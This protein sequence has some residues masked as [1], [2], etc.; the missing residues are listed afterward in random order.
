MDYAEILESIRKILSQPIVLVI[1]TALTAIG[2]LIAA[3]AAVKANKPN[4]REKTD[5][6]KCELLN[7]LHSSTGLEVW[8]RS[9]SLGTLNPNTISEFLDI[10]RSKQIIPS[11]IRIG[12]LR[13]IFKSR[14]YSKYEW[15]VYIIAAMCE[16]SKEGY[17]IVRLGMSNANEKI[18]D[19]SYEQVKDLLKNLDIPESEI[20]KYIQ[21]SPY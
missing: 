7:L 1:F 2:A 13:N 15:K 11:I 16:L 9:A 19:A 10:E 14:L 18:M 12:V 20:H 5:I 17:E 6:I 4:S 21:I 3:R 8:S